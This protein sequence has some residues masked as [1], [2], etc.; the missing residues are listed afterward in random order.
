MLG[1][2]PGLV[3]TGYGVIEP[4]AGALTVVDA[5]V[6]VTNASLPL[7]DRIALIYE[8]VRELITARE[9]SLVVLEDLYMEYRF[10]RTALLMAHARGVVCLAVRQAG[11]TLLALAPSQVKSAVTAN[12]AASKEQ[13]QEVVRRR[14]SLASTPRP[15]HVADALGL[16]LAGLSRAGVV[17]P[18]RRPR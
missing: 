17:T 15:S 18:V 11:V 6:I 3:G 1:I 9:P 5:G 8:G 2:D 16:A 7:E 12:G 4:V 13:V 14:L 10:P